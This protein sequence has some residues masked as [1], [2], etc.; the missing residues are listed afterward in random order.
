MLSCTGDLRSTRDAIR[1]GMTV[2]SRFS[3]RGVVAGAGSRPI[4]EAEPVEISEASL[5]RAEPCGRTGQANVAV[6]TCKSR[7]KRGFCQVQHGVS[8]ARRGDRREK[9]VDISIIYGM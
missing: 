6:L 4:A 7:A 8:Q 1:L 2:G 5:D 3:C 9:A